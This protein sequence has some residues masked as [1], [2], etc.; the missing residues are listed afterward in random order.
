MSDFLFER[1]APQF[2]LENYEYFLIPVFAYPIV[3][4]YNVFPK[5]SIN[6]VKTVSFLWNLT[7][8]TYS[9]YTVYILFPPLV[10]KL[11]THGYHET[12]CLEHTRDN[13]FLRQPWGIWVLYFTVSKV[14]E[15]FDTVLLKMKGKELTFLHC[16]HH[17]VTL[18]LSY[19]ESL[20]LREPLIWGAV[21][22]CSVHTLMYMYY[23][24]HDIS[25]HDK[26]KLDKIA[27]TITTVQVV[28]MLHG[29]FMTFYNGT[30]CENVP[31]LSRPSLFVYTIYCS[32]FMMFFKKK[33]L[34]SKAI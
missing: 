7:L 22:N 10:T 21:M 6:I 17:I 3:L 8:A 18:I 14:F 16:Y 27:I 19:I 12:V 31:S 28:Q 5:M 33:Y 29:M 9:G 13:S 26:Y 15:L 25:L 32:M 34:K 20:Q 24:A 2:L 11:Y 23:A 4:Y 1:D 30:Y